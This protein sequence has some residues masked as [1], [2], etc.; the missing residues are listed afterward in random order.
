L[1]DVDAVNAALARG[2]YERAADV[3]AA[4][5]ERGQRHPTLFNALAF[6]HSEAG[7]YEAALALLRQAVEIDPRDVHVLYSIGFCL[8]RLGRN[9]EALVAF[10]SVLAIRPG[11]PAAMHHK[12]MLLEQKGDEAGAVRCYEMAMRSDPNYEDPYAGLASIAA[13]RGD[14]DRAREYARRALAIAPLQPT[15]HLAIARADFDAGQFEAV[16]ARLKPLVADARLSPLEQPAFQALLGDAL[17]ALDR[18]EEAFAAWAEGKRLSLEQYADHPIAATAGRHLER[19]AALKP[20]AHTLEPFAPALA[21]APPA[22][23][24]PRQHAFLVGFPRSGTTLLEQV[25]A[26]HD[27]VVTLGERPLLDP[28]ELEFLVSPASF[29]RLLDADD[30]ELDPFRERY[31]RQL[32]AMGL[33]IAGTVFIDKLPLGSLLIPLIARLFPTARVLFVERDPRDVVLGC[34]RRAFSMN[35]GMYQFVTLEGAARFYDQVM[36]LAGQYRRLAPDRVHAVRYEEL[37]ADFEGECRRLCD[38][39]GLDWSPSLNDFARTAR[40]RQIR[41]PSAPQIRKGLYTSAVGQWRRYERQ[42]APVLPILA[43]WVSAFG[44]ERGEGLEAGA[45]T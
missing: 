36:A 32:E 34:F 3:S 12:G 27:D 11:F 33:N 16:E 18:C 21:L 37:V 14:F 23:G 40:L 20:F 7:R 24:L 45:P 19:M 13:G 15:A 29:Q 25:L 38:F 6:R 8:F 22:P 44:Y 35:P 9:E 30:D 17:D 10:D 41:T 42:L 1:S 26:S 39:V 2:D 31:W 4:A 5:L 28:A 43:P